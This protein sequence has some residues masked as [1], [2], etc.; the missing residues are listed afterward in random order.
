MLKTFWSDLYLKK[1]KSKSSSNYFLIVF[2]GTIICMWKNP[3][4][5][6][7]LCSITQPGIRPQVGK[8]Q[9]KPTL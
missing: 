8:G 7:S 9:W 2:K 5:I 1:K 6:F 3:A 4:L